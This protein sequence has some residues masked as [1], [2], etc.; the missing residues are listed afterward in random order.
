ML[1]NASVRPQEFWDT[2]AAHVAAMVHPSLWQEQ[3]ERGPVI[4]YLR[5]LDAL[6]RRECESRDTFQII[7]SAR[8]VL[9]DRQKVGP[10]NG[11]FCR[12]R[13]S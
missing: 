10:M 3:C 11:P 5:D 4:A 7:A 12:F 6:V 1:A 2:S 13:A 9:G 8:H